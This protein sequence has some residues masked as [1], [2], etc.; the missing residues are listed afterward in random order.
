[1]K[2]GKIILLSFAII[3]L[4][5]CKKEQ[6]ERYTVNKV[7]MDNAMAVSYFHTVFREAENAWAYIDSMK[8]ELETYEITSGKIMCKFRY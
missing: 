3:L 2:F 7:L 6:K 5:N 4:V 8:Y 1:M